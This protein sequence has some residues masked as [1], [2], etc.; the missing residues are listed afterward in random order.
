MPKPEG[1]CCEAIWKQLEIESDEE[2][3]I[4]YFEK[5]NEYGLND[6][7]DPS[8]YTPITFCPEVIISILRALTSCTLRV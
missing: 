5:G 3:L 7:V 8:A 2:Q 1:Y 6:R 4:S